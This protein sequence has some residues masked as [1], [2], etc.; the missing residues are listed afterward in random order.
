MIGEADSVKA[1]KPV[2]RDTKPELVFLDIEMPVQNGFTLLEEMENFEFDV[3]FT[4]A[5]DQYAIKAFEYSAV[6]YLLKPIKMS[7]LQKAINK[8]KDKKEKKQRL[9]HIQVL[10]DNF[11]KDFHKIV[12][13]TQE[14]F[15]FLEVKNIV[16]CAADGNYTCFY[17]V[18]GDKVLVSKTLK[19][20]EELLDTKDFLRIHQ[21]HLINLQ[22]IRK[23]IKGKAGQVEMLDDSVLDVSVR[24]KAALLARIKNL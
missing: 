1:A 5:F 18:D 8:V 4:T 13:P 19:H 22:H 23:Y 6:D 15:L 7:K 24:R 16:R 10:R 14:G 9:E 2:I 12:L 11:Q 3:I 20:I 17:L 21:S